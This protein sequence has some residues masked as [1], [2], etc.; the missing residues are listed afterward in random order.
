MLVWVLASAK[1][2]G[3]RLWLDLNRVKFSESYG[4]CY[5]RMGELFL[6]ASA[7]LGSHLR[8]G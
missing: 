2:A 5:G 3:G 4:Y 7:L 6:G 8:L 1:E